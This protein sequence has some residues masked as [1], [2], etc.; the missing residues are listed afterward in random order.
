MKA[1]CK[2]IRVTSFARRLPLLLGA[3]ALLLASCGGSDL[4]A[5]DDPSNGANLAFVDD[6]FA[7]TPTS[8]TLIAAAPDVVLSDADSEMVRFEST[9]I[10]ELQRRT[11]QT[12]S[13]RED[14]LQEKL[15]EFGLT[16][17]DYVA[18][19][20]RVNNDQDLR[21]AILYSYQETCRP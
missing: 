17:P 3:S 8:T 1:N 11:F 5:D 4:I 13:G 16:E 12:Q 20:A 15:T 21:D 6:E 14:A 19:R 2:T 18:F 9:W 10:C 7:D